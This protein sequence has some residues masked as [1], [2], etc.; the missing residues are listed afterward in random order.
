MA[1]DLQGIAPRSAAPRL[2]AAFAASTTLH[3]VLAVALHWLPAG[4]LFSDEVRGLA[5]SR[6]LRAT[7]RPDSRAVADVGGMDASSVRAPDSPD[8]QAE[9]PGGPA[10]LS[11][12]DGGVARQPGILP[13]RRY[14]PPEELDRKPQVT[15]AVEPKFPERATEPMGRV[16]LRLLVNE[17][18]GVDEV[19]VEESEPPGVFDKAAREAFLQAR[20]LPGQRS[21]LDV[22]SA[23]RI[24]VLYGQPVP[25]PKISPRG[26]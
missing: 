14:F 18:G 16:V 7:L 13:Q 1:G 9:P 26:Y 6:S 25:A 12:S 22:K 15:V 3:A 24:E 2:A 17:S 4:Q 10:D 11:L 21:G 20:F 8:T 19:I 23:L 5:G